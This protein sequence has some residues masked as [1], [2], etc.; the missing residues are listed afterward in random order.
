MKQS[1]IT[2]LGKEKSG[3][4]LATSN[5]KLFS[6]SER[7]TVQLEPVEVLAQ[8]DARAGA[9]DQSD[10]VDSH[11]ITTTVH[12][13]ANSHTTSNNNAAAGKSGVG[14]NAARNRKRSATVSGGIKQNTNNN[15][16]LGL[17]GGNGSDNSSIQDID[18][19]H[20][21]PLQTFNG[22]PGAGGKRV[23]RTRVRS[24]STSFTTYLAQLRRRSSDSQEISSTQFIDDPNNRYSNVS[25]QQSSQNLT[26]EGIEGSLGKA[27][28][29]PSSFMSLLNRLKSNILGSGYLA[30]IGSTTVLSDY[31]KAGN[32]EESEFDASALDPM[33]LLEKLQAPR[34]SKWV[35]P[36]ITDEMF[37]VDILFDGRFDLYNLSRRASQE[38]HKSAEDPD[39]GILSPEDD[40]ERRAS[41]FSDES[42]D[43]FE[44]ELP[45]NIGSKSR[46]N[47]FS[48]SFVTA[49]E[50]VISQVEMQVDA[51]DNGVPAYREPPAYDE[52]STTSD[53]QEEEKHE[54]GEELHAT[55]ELK[56][57][58]K[59]D[60]GI[61]ITVE[62]ASPTSQHGNPSLAQRRPSYEFI[63]QAPRLPKRPTPTALPMANPVIAQVGTK[64]MLKFN[65]CTTLFTLD[66]SL[67]E[68]SN[69][70][71]HLEVT[72]KVI[73]HAIAGHMERTHSLFEI[74]ADYDDHPKSAHHRKLLSNRVFRNADVLNERLFPIWRVRSI[75]EE[76]MFQPD[77][78]SPPTIDE[79]YQFLR[80]V[81]VA[82][83][84]SAE[85]AIVSLIYLERMMAYTHIPLF[86]L[87]CFRSVLGA[88]MMA[89]KIWDDQAVWNVD[90]KNIMEDLELYGLH[91]LERW[92]LDQV[93]WDM[94]VSRSIFASYWFEVRQLSEKLYGVR[95]HEVRKLHR[96]Q[97]EVTSKHQHGGHGHVGKSGN[98]MV[99]S[100]SR[101]FDDIRGSN[102]SLARKQ[103][104]RMKRDHSFNMPRP[105]KESQ[106][107]RIA[108]TTTYG[109]SRLRQS[110]AEELSYK[111][112]ADAEGLRQ[113]DRVL[114]T[115]STRYEPSPSSNSL[116]SSQAIDVPSKRDT[117][118][119]ISNLASSNYSVASSLNG[120]TILAESNAL[121]SHHIL[122]TG[123]DQPTT[124]THTDSSN[125]AI[126]VSNAQIALASTLNAAVGTEEKRL[127]KQEESDFGWGGSK[128]RRAKSDYIYTPTGPNASVL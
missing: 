107:Q 88:I 74:L 83:D 123:N 4:K 69:T 40:D 51:T 66:S 44:H 101:N 98:T 91:E 70:P 20:L 124:T 118:I 87:N 127:S 103:Q 64:G 67:Y 30:P 95:I 109:Q 59:D 75:P 32:E 120:K 57:D 106:V 71:E 3:N 65:S 35:S 116:S 76:V 92:W 33:K 77:I 90:F 68:S 54:R 31:A 42:S 111:Q 49:R 100:R 85:V 36:I 21:V 105:L 6:G 61:Q 27:H 110:F 128:L 28:E 19:Q 53:Q 29:Q 79:V 82:A 47:S 13:S 9:I 121:H 15:N 16:L 8:L 99:N 97:T 5:P 122:A 126:H 14:M 119:S 17:L 73:S 60:Y 94:N 11:P 115:T 48:G 43:L 39:K 50:S 80:Q 104:P 12:Y 113:L 58:D 2:S 1:S 37:I 34:K 114:S 18:V 89:S 63:I 38:S 23:S 45:P 24:A 81:F 26:P 102:G 52:E 117:T 112:A 56:H 62:A 46:S 41:V 108:A 7:S 125:S 96:A 78:M 84:L 10:V 55:Q 93:Q 86:G 72:L 25:I 22:Q